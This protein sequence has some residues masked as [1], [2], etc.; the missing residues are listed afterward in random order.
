M[1]RV[2]PFG[3]AVRGPSTL[4]IICL[5]RRTKMTCTWRAPSHTRSPQ[6]L[7]PEGRNPELI[8][9]CGV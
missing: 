6:P 7:E 9:P 1:F 3:L 4:N 5:L 2:T 8:A